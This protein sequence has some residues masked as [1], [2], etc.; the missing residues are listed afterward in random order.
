MVTL[1]SLSSMI[2]WRSQ[3]KTTLNPAIIL[4]IKTARSYVTVLSTAVEERS[5]R[6]IN[7]RNLVVKVMLAFLMTPFGFI[8]QSTVSP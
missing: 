1:K 7:H 3:A 2:F 5:W 4:A 8:T 6:T